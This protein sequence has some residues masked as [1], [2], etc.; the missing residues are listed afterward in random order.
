MVRLWDLDFGINPQDQRLELKGYD[1][2]SR[3]WGVGPM[4]GV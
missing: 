2:G 1:L 3:K 4:K